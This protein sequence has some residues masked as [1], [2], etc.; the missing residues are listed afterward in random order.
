MMD[1]SSSGGGGFESEKES[2][3][4]Q[5]DLQTAYW[6]E[7]ILPRIT[8]EVLAT[9]LPPPGPQPGPPGAAWV[10]ASASVAAMGSATAERK[11]KRDNL[12]EAAKEVMMEWINQHV[13][14]PYPTKEEKEV[15]SLR[16]GLTT[17]QISNWFTNA[18]RRYLKIT[19]H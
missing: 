5:L 13:A 3:L 2:L 1:G 8:A 9:P 10:V 18:R 7:N 14:D 17:T 15:L 4:R 11:R 16:T 6:S 12:D 19:E